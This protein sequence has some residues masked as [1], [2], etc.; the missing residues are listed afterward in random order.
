M[1]LYLA[2]TQCFGH[3]SHPQETKN[4]RVLLV[5]W[6][7]PFF[8]VLPLKIFVQHDIVCKTT[9][10]DV[11]ACMYVVCLT[12]RTYQIKKL[13]VPE[14]GGVLLF[15]FASLIHEMAVLFQKVDSLLRMGRNVIILILKQKNKVT[16]LAL[17]SNELEQ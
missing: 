3:F 11:H 1:H 13:F 8:G 2:I 9:V 14:F 5:R 4:S 15:D 16:E 12:T 17:H 7:I 6:Q 10:Y